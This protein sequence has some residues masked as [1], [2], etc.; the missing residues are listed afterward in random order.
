MNFLV[1]RT[2]ADIPRRCA[3]S[4]TAPGSRQEVSP[5]AFGH[6]LGQQSAAQTFATDG[7]LWPDR[8]DETRDAVDYVR[9]GIAGA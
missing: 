1:L 9:P 5:A 4:H 2:L 7:H 3:G 8:D 6:R